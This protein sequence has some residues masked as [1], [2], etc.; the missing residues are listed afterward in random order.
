[1]ILEHAFRYT[2]SM[3]FGLLAITALMLLSPFTAT[4][5]SLDSLAGSTEPF[6]VSINPRYPAPYSQAVVSLLSTT[7][8]LTNASMSVSVGGKRIYQGSVKPVAIP[9]GRA[10]SAASVAIT[11]T[12]A[13]T[14]Y[15]QSFVIQPQDVSLIAEPNASVPALYPGKPLIPLE[16][17]TRVVAIA[18]LRDAGGKS[19]NA[20]SLSYSWSVDGV[21]IANASGIGKEAIVVAS[22]LQY[23]DRS[24]SVVVRSQNGSLVGGASLS[25]SPAEPMMRIY[26]NDPLLG[27]L[28]DHALS[29]TYTIADTEATLYGVPYSFPLLGGA[30]RIQW[31]LNGDLAQTGDSITLRPSGSGAGSASLSASASAGTSVSATVSLPLSFGAEKSFNFFG[32]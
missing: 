15:S 12:I 25:F 21:Q 13:G 23:R 30:P 27:I 4:A 2:R 5:Q 3:R 16:G 7:L 26:K 11:V 28:F 19:A 31:F 9:L 6:T 1:M 10:G 29:G 14:P 8:D 17:N 32:L 22:P 20:S 18:N 24:V